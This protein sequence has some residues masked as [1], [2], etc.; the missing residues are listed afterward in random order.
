MLLTIITFIIILGL[1]VFVHEFGHFIV[2]KRNGMR[3][4]E[5]GFGFP[6][7]MVGIRK[8]NGKWKWV[9]GGKSNFQEMENAPESADT[10]YSI[11]WIPLGGFVRIL[12][13]NNEREDDPRSFINRPAWARFQTL[14]AGVAMNVILAWLL[15]SLGYAVGL[16]VAVNGPEDV[17]ANAAFTEQR[18]AI[19]DVQPDSP[20]SRAGI[21]PEDMVSEIDGRSF[22]SVDDMQNYILENKG[23]V[24]NF[25]IIRQ[26]QP[27]EISVQSIADPAEGQGPTGIGLALVGK[28]RFPW[29]SAA[30]QGLQT[31]YI[32]A[33]AILG[34]LYHL[35][36][37]RAGLEAVGGPVKIAQLTGQVARMG[38]AYLVQFTAFL[39]L[40]LALLNILPFPALDGGRVLFLIIEKIRG[41]R[42]NQKIEQWVNAAGFL[43]LLLLM[44]VVTVKDIIQR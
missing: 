39:S 25:G 38:F 15:V 24:F 9:W 31:V 20:A 18:V 6:P 30:W 32:Q 12:G 2:A 10:I 16:P 8:V 5:F 21:K 7:R 33:G 17:P 27:V 29:Y 4:E 43:L 14:V 13:E 40:N 1:L 36:T 26:N 11:N 3:V 19:L 28:M 23:K 22:A 34:G 37:S 42:N 41:R 35:F 44:L